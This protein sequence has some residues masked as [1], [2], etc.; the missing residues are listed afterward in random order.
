M[1][2][3]NLDAPDSTPDR[4]HTGRAPARWAAV[5]IIAAAAALLLALAAWAVLD[6]HQNESDSDPAWDPGTV[7]AIGHVHAIADDPANPGTGVLLATHA[8]VYAV[9]PDGAM[10]L[11]GADGDDVMSLVDA[12]SDRLLA[13]GH[14]GPDSTDPSPNLG[15]VESDDAGRTWRPLSLDGADFHAIAPAGDLT[16]ALDTTTG[17]LLLSTDDR[18]W[19]TVT[20]EPLL[21][22][23]VDPADPDRV[24]ATNAS[25]KVPRDHLGRVDRHASANT[26]PG[27]AR[28]GGRRV[29]R[30]T[31]RRC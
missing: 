10:R 15:L 14:P 28:L 2:S 13:S 3:T 16:W 7:A 27:P 11:A 9:A 4:P 12:G 22:I 6:P 29:R 18:V 24:L 30:R 21:D 5:V 25:G 8:G 23:A 26:A 20:S 19:R 31:G 17:G 1:T